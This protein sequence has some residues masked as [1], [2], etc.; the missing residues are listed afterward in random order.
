MLKSA[1]EIAPTDDRKLSLPNQTW[2]GI[3]ATIHEMKYLAI[4][5][6]GSGQ[7]PYLLQ[8]K[9]RSDN[10]EVISSFRIKCVGSLSIPN[11]RALL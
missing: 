11:K 9:L 6:L 5:C 1:S 4:Q 7:V 2:T 3:N 10:I 8:G